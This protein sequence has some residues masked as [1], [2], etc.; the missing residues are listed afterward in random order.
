M[1]SLLIK[2]LLIFSGCI[3]CLPL[4]AQD[5]GAITLEE[6]ILLALRYNPNVVNKELDRVTEKFS[7]AQ[8][9]RQFEPRYSLTAS[10]S[11]ATSRSTNATDLSVSRSESAGVNVLPGVSIKNGIG[12][13]LSVNM[14]NSY[15]G[16]TYN[17]SLSVEVKQPLLKGFGPDIVWI[18]LFNAIES[19]ELNQLGLRDQVIDTIIL[20]INQYFEL[21]SQQQN[22]AI[23]QR[24]L[25]S[26]IETVEDNELKIKIGEMAETENI[27]ARAQVAKNE[28]AV[29]QARNSLD[30]SR[31]S[32]LRALGLDP[33]TQ[34]ALV[35]KAQEVALLNYSLPS[36]VQAKK[37]ALA[38][39]QSY[40]AQKITR[41]SL[42]RALYKAENDKLWEINFNWSSNFGPG[43]GSGVNA[44]LASIVNDTNYNHTASL[45]VTVPM[46]PE[47]IN[48]N[49]IQAK[50]ALQKN[51][52]SLKEEAY[53][54]ENDV[55][56]ALRDLKVLQIQIQQSKDAE[57]LARQAYDNELV[58]QEYGESSQ[59][60]VNSLQDQL[61]SAQL[62]VVRQQISYIN[63]LAEFTKLVGTTLDDWDIAL[64]Y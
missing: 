11:Y 47:T 62:D 40:R 15:N 31:Q 61:R 42:Q 9:Y 59:F 16:N 34:F 19:E 54:I 30:N 51:A 12:T 58:K 14:G 48:E 57:V 53:R 60:E 29:T 17:P 32:F 52:I 63:R 13:E 18:D 3:S 35:E 21:L 46:D 23:Q 4:Y 1:K 38:F 8:Q 43:A 41:K 39:S 2:V 49:L 25:E 44:G 33:Q 26:S 22:L 7:L 20:V 64:V 27:Q 24:S 37:M 36:L 56:N 6:A 55:I 5:V 28:L 45:N 50:I 10:S